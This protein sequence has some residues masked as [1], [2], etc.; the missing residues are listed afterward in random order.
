M[1][2]GGEWDDQ[3]RMCSW[4][5]RYERRSASAMRRQ[6]SASNSTTSA[7]ARRRCIPLA[8][9]WCARQL[10]FYRVLMAFWRG[11][12]LKPS[13]AGGASAATGRRAVGGRWRR[14]RRRR[15]PSPRPCV[16]ESFTSFSSSVGLV[17]D[18]AEREQKQ[19][20]IDETCIF[21]PSSTPRSS[22]RTT[23]SRRGSNGRPSGATTST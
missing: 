11:V 23:S 9:R 5:R 17:V 2:R 12:F 22:T 1:E 21:W 8:W 7:E 13:F 15:P 6:A 18:S 3:R 4:R 10:G 20:T 19:K 16:A 14:G